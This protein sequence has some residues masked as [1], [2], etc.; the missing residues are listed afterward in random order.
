METE[1][2]QSS[3]LKSGTKTNHH[4]QNML[5][6]ILLCQAQ[7]IPFAQRKTA[8]TTRKGQRLTARTSK[9]SRLT[10]LMTDLMLFK[11]WTH[12]S[13]LKTRC[14]WGGPEVRPGSDRERKME[15]AP[16]SLNPHTERISHVLIPLFPSGTNEVINQ[17]HGP[18]ERGKRGPEAQREQSWGGQKHHKNTSRLFW[19]R[20][21]EHT[22]TQLSLH[23]DSL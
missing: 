17:S 16:S 20:G 8:E 9:P 11:K 18:T 6:T 2:V 10:L 14:V 22:S 21:L 13:L 3:S 5:R 7:L 4:T 19:E 23:R 12:L 15:N 1:L